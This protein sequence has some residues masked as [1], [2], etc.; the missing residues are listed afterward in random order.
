MAG[1]HDVISGAVDLVHGSL[2]YTWT[3][4]TDPWNSDHYSILIE[5]N[6]IIQPGKC[7]IGA[8]KLQNKDTDW[9]AFME[10]VKEKITEVKTHSS[11]NRER[12]VKERCENFI[13]IIKVKLE[14]TTPKRKNK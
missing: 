8:S 9:T 10:K 4:G 12:D 3:I 6:G 11:W 7:S 5:Y 2:L 1:G 13:Q 14:E